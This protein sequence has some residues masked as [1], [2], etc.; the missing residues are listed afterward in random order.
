[1]TT[2]TDKGHL[3]KKQIA[4]L[5]TIRK[6]DDNGDFLDVD[7]LLLKLPYETSKASFQ[8]SIRALVKRGLVA[9]GY[10]TRRG[11]NR[12]TY[13]LTPEAVRRFDGVTG[14]YDVIV[15]GMD[16][17]EELIRSL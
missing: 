16:D 8:F 1:M 5:E 12:V 15:E 7:T 6:G 14:Q 3:T 9:K 13:S 11:R 10:E 17:I 2:S 4:I